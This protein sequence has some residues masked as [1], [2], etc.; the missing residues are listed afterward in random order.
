VTCPAG[1]VIRGS[2]GDLLLRTKWEVERDE[3]Q[4]QERHGNILSGIKVPLY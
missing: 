3:D 4:V 2:Q 1:P